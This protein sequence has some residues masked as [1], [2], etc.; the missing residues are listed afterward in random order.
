[1]ATKTTILILSISTVLM[2]AVSLG[3]ATA[4]VKSG[5]PGTPFWLRSNSTQE[6]YVMRLVFSKEVIFDCLLHS[7]NKV[8]LQVPQVDLF[9]EEQVDDWELMQLVAFVVFKIAFAVSFSFNITLLD[10]NSWYLTLFV[11]LQPTGCKLGD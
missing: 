7:N 5:K 1:M 6:N 3:T 9:M 2:Y 4:P 10:A 11:H 8:E